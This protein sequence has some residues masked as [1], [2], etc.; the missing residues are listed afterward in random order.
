M[1]RKYDLISELY[2][3]TCASVSE[4]PLNWQGLL[5]TASYNFRLR[6]DEQLLLYAQR[7]DA[8]AVLPIERWNGSFGRW[9][10]RGAKG[11]AVFEDENR[12]R[13][14]LTHYFD[15]SDTHGSRY[16]RPVPLWQMKLEYESDV[17]E[18]LENT[19]GEAD[20]NSTLES[21]IEGCVGNAVDDNIADYLADLQSLQEGSVAQSL[22]PDAARDIYTQLVKQSVAYMITVRLGLDTSRYSAESFMN[23]GYFNTPEMINAVG[24][25]TSDIAEMGLT[26]IARTINALE[27]QNRIIAAENHSDYNRNENNERSNDNGRNHLFDGGRLQS[28][29]PENAGAAERES[30]QMGADEAVLSERPSQNPVLQSA[31]QRNADAALGGGS[32][33]SDRDGG[34]ARQADGAERGSDRGTES[35]RYDEVGSPDEQSEEL[36]A[37][38][39]E[40][41]SNIRLEYYDRNNE[42]RSLPFFGNDETI[43]EMLRTTPHLKASKEEIDAFYEGHTDNGER[44]E[45]IKSIFNN[46]YTHLTLD[47]GRLVGYKTY[48]NVLHL[49]EG[50]YD[51]R[52]AQSFYDWGVIAQH[53][54]AMRLLGELTDE[55][56]PLP[57]M[58]GQFTLILDSQAE[59]RKTSAFTFSQE[60]IDEVLTRGSGVSEGKM[61][62][63][64]QFEKSL[65]AKEN[66]DF[67]KSEYG[68]GGVS[69]VIVG[70]GISEWHDGKGIHLTKGSLLHPDAEL[71]LSWQQVEKRIGELIRIDR[72]LNPKEKEA[73]PD[74]LQKQEERRAEAAEQRRNREIL[75][76]APPQTETQTNEQEARYEYHLG[77]SVYIGASEYEILSFDESR[78]MLYDTQMPLFNK[79]LTREEFDRKVRENPM[80]DHLKVLDTPAEEER[81]DDKPAPF[82]INEYDDPDYYEQRQ[83]AEQEAQEQKEAGLGEYLNPE[84]EETDPNTTPIGEIDYFFHR[85]EA[86]EYE[87]IYYNPDA[88][89]GGQFVILHLPYDLIAEAKGKT[90]TAE[91]FFDFLDGHAY[92]ELIDLGTP[93]YAEMLIEYAEPMP[94]FIGRSEET[95]LALTERSSREIPEQETAPLVPKWEQ[96]KKQKVK[97]FDL[98]PDIPMSER[99]TFDLK[100]NPVETVGKKER[101]RRNI[102]AIQLLKKCQEE[103]RFATPD[104][105]II[106]SK[107]VGW[108]GIPEAFDENNSAWGTEYLELKTVLTPEE[109]TAARESTLTAFY[110]P[111]EVTTAIYNALSQMG[112]REGNLLEPSCGIGNFIGMLPQS[113]ENAKIYGVELDPISAGIAQQLYQKSS[114]AA[115]G[116]EEVN[117]PDSFFDGVVGNVPFGD[118]KVLDK[119]YDKHN[120]LIHDY[121][122]A[123]S[124]DKL[125]PGGL[126]ALVT[127]K[128]TMDKTNPAV[129]KYIAQRADLLG[130]I[131]LPNN[132]FK[133]NAGTEVV[134]DIL[135]LQKRDR[136]IDIEPDWVHLDTDE[137][138]IEMNSYFVRHPEMVLGEMKMVTGRFGLESTCEPYENA[139][140][141]SQ[142]AEAVSNIHGEISDYEVDDEM[143]SED[144][145]IPANPSVR[146]FSYTVVDDVIYFRE[147]SKMTPVEVSA[148]AENRIKGMIAIR[149]CVRELIEL[150]TEDYPDSEI[151]QAQEKLNTLYDNFTKKYGLINSRANTS[152]FNA[153]SSYALLAALEVL[154]ENG[155]LERKA[156]MFTKRTIKPHIPVTEVDTASEALAVSMG[157]KATVDM[158]YM[159]QLT[160]KTEQ[161]LYSDLK[162][163]IFLNPLYG[164]GNSTEPKYLMADEYLSGNVREKLALAKRSA[165]VYPEDYTVNVEALEKVQPKDLTASEISV[166]LGATWLPPEIAQQFMYEFLDTPLW[167]RWNIKVHFSQYSGEWNVEGKSYDRGNV[168]AYN[169]YGTSRINAYKIIEETLNLKDVRIFDYI[170]DDEGKKKAVL[171]KKETA[172]A[173]SK[174]ELIKQ[175]FQDWI[176]ADPTRREKLTKLYNEKFNSIRP[177]EYDGSHITFS[178]MNPEIELREHQKN[179]VAHIL[180]GGN[181]L[182]AHAVGAG[183]TYEMV[184]AAQDS[185]R[186]GLCNKSLFVVP[187]HLTE[188]WAAEY[189]QLYPSANILV[190]TKKDFE[191]K[192]RKKFC[193]RIATG[194]YDA[195]IIG[196]SQFE[197]IPMSIERQRAILEQQ[198]E[199]VAAGI[200]DLKRNRGENFSIKQLE[201]TRKSIKQKLEKLNDQTRKD[202]VVTFEELGVDRLFID[203]S[204]YYKNLYLYTKMRNVG[205]I[206]QTEAQKSSDLFMKCR[207]L[208]EITGGRGTVFATGTPISNS[209]VELYTIQ[210]YLQYATLER[211]NLQ[212]FDAWAST[213]GE[214]VTAVELTPEGTGYRAKTRFARFYNLPELM[215]MFKEVA[216]IKTADMLDLPVPKANFHN[217]SVKPSEIQKEMVKA[218]AERAEKV[219]SGAVD[220]SVD[221][222]LK[223]TN[224]GRKLA[225][226]QRLLN[227]MLPDF[228]GS[229]LNACVNEMFKTWEKGKEKRLTQLFF[230]DLSTPKNDGNFS[231]YDDIR[232]KLIEKGVPADEIKFI[233]EADTEAKKLELFKKVRR[234]DVRI[235][236]GS[237]QKMGAGT[238]VQDKLAASSDLDCPWRPSDLEQRLG[239]SIRQG[240]SNAEV[241]VF[242]FVTEETFDAYLYQ[243]VEGKQKFASQ[244]M[245]SKS[246]VRSAEDIDET[247][248]SYA[249]IKMLATGNPY[250]KEKMDLDIQVQKLKLLKSNFLS[251]KYSL[252]D[253]IIKYYPQ[254]IASMHSR[255]EGLKADV[256]TA[257]EHPKPTDDRFAGMEVKGVFYT[258]K[259]E[260][261]KAIIEACK[262]M[263]SPDPV[264]LGAYRGFTTELLFD[265]V[266]RQYVVRLKGETSR[267]VP[268]GEDIHGNITRIDNGIERFE[269]MLKGAENDLENTEKQF[270]TAKA[271]AEKPFSKEEELK[272]KMARLDELNILLNLDKNE[273]EIV[274]GEPDEGEAQPEKRE[275]DYER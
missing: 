269:E 185:K 143:E 248:L 205:G 270:E 191:T 64:E 121:F 132:T 243:L 194:D 29:E 161:E 218:L 222:M 193:G 62:I 33:E 25:A 267:N 234:G 211:N 172:I 219:H 204:H 98:H 227:P 247:A 128:G 184:A 28:S 149:D 86:E 51:S 106:L 256:K 111:P 9:V 38:S 259:A 215:A 81:S 199:E 91:D 92:T 105:Q 104:E 135:F 34:N 251:E 30:G 16:A 238:N 209:M 126:M 7:P 10:N 13:Q 50:E 179:A 254:R 101:F 142:L 168:K 206:A 75:S 1:A 235:L 26:E 139:N 85:P 244:I 260:A 239:R 249:E 221:N 233:H 187:N 96:T 134:S 146:N 43:N 44:T 174:Q 66:A 14:R 39:G 47:D 72:Y 37:G 164:Y 100:A 154:D 181:T 188:Q 210:R 202:D 21:I 4:N 220:A 97:G 54:Q 197:K 23:I 192:N 241:D 274:G 83:L 216:D 237:T 120:F 108:G 110:T 130:A 118:F 189:L 155:E 255:I 272:S 5:R 138:G 162:G 264:P 265:T 17:A 114:I 15:I 160:G 175:G 55:M 240:N 77:D 102:M 165:E 113:M 171:N 69:T 257:Q 186:L 94:D 60:I 225:L 151:K 71:Q 177:R 273:N 84:K 18:T 123:K 137:N 31:D 59:E 45:Y 246:P 40:S 6:F 170:E 242:R 48:Q 147:N 198:L 212:H 195:I 231:V 183:K 73:Y 268:L 180:Y 27:K 214:T 80:N 200:M 141:E 122:F 79:E 20:D 74:W 159:Q 76:A 261:G 157:E 12:Q 88:V 56:K 252:E 11:I 148:T 145:S 87:A 127:S 228:E 224:D 46:D 136:L 22:L 250:I 236:M 230:C 271:E 24:F 152:A 153:D 119:R 131:R 226:D 68:W 217:I 107:Y 140:L 190:A 229:K 65:S 173:Q 61:R 112:F 144:N 167:A 35:D 99:N 201:K 41:G 116:F 70:T 36:G 156:D 203:E 263:N 78:V 63:Y 207:Y 196:H 133:G 32:T 67:L 178:G 166:R 129:R 245:T 52:T 150:Q 275:R 182:L 2:D 82:D 57:S 3:R 125:R 213:F 208:D 117:V 103:N 232:K 169:T 8:T 42:D 95:M 253:K 258:E 266:E 176:W 53:F 262:E 58:D 124:L 158:P 93:E 115:R 90:E 19:F 163:V 223:I 109:Y 89:A 49:W